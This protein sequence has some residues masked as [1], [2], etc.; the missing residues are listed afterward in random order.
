MCLLTVIVFDLFKVS[1]NVCTVLYQ[2][3]S[4]SE[5]KEDGGGDPLEI[6]EEVAEGQVRSQDPSY[7]FS[8][9]N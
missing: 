2:K 3:Q 6:S 8:L 5:A 9:S 1:W 4:T 7:Q